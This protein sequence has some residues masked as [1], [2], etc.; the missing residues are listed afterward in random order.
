M[1]KNA[2]TETQ[3][4]QI[5]SGQD[6]SQQ[7]RSNL[8]KSGF[9]DIKI[10]PQ[11]FLI[12]AQDPQGNPIEMVV[13]PT[14]IAAVD[15][16]KWSGN[17]TTGRSVAEQAARF[18]QG[19]VYD[20]MNSNLADTSV[21]SSDKKNVGTIKGI[22]IGENG[23]LSYVVTVSGDHDVAADPLAMTL[24]Y[25]DSADKWSASVDATKKQIDSAPQAQYNQKSK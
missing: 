1:Q 22:A 6:L 18:V 19:P 3:P 25:D 13:S 17:P 5:L 20:A 23:S 10:M 12:R 9:S 4:S 11:S 8:Q 16:G 15:V 21:Q 7:L 24:S 2:V 14:S